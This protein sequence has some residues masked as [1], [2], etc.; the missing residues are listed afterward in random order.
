MNLVELK[1]FIEEHEN[2][3]DHSWQQVAFKTVFENFSIIP[4]KRGLCKNPL[5]KKEASFLKSPLE[6][7]W[8]NIDYKSFEELPKNLNKLGIP[9]HKNKLIV[10]DVDDPELFNQF[11][12]MNNLPTEY[13]TFTVGT[14]DKRYHLYFNAPDDGIAYPNTSDHN[15]GFD[16]RG[17]KCSY[18]VSFASLHPVTGK[19]Y[20]ILKSVP[21]MDA[22]E[23]VLNWLLY[24]NVNGKVNDSSSSVL[25]TVPQPESQMD[26]SSLP[27]TKQH[28]VENG[29][30]LHFR[31]EPSIGVM[32]SM[33][34]NGFTDDQIRKVYETM[35]IGEKAR[36]NGYQWFDAELNRAKA[37]VAGLT[38]KNTKSKQKSSKPVQV[39]EVFKLMEGFEYFVDQYGIYYAKDKTTAGIRYLE[40]HSD[41]YQGSILTRYLNQYGYAVSIQSYKAALSML[42]YNLIGKAKPIQ[43]ICRFGRLGDKLILDL[44]TDTGDCIEIS[45]DGY[46]KITQPEVLLERNENI[47]PIEN[48]QMGC[49]GLSACNTFL[50]VQ[51]ITNQN[52]RHYLLMVLVSYLFPEISSP[53]LYFYG[54]QGSGK[55]FRALTL[56]G[57]FDKSTAGVYLGNNILEL[58]LLL[59]KS[60]ITFVDNF[61]SLNANCQN[62]FCLAYSDGKFVKKKNYEDTKT[63]TIDMKC[64][65]MLASVDIPDLQEDFISRTAFLSVK[66]NTG[67]K[68]E[69]DLWKEI[70]NV[71]PMVRGELCW[72]ASEILKII[73]EYEPVNIKRHADF[74]KLGQAYC[75]II[76]DN[77]DEYKNII[78]NRVVSD[79]I[80]RVGAD[81]VVSEIVSLVK[82]KVFYI[83][84]MQDL[85][86]ELK[87]FIDIAEYKLTPSSLSKKIDKNIKLFTDLGITVIDGPKADNGH[88]YAM[89]T[90]D[91]FNSS[92]SA[93]KIIPKQVLLSN[94][95]II[96]SLYVSSTPTEIDAVIDSILNDK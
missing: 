16:G 81:E 84:T 89:V 10:I 3:A 7:N 41:E 74:D 11:C 62:S 44:G 92:N 51:G 19:P 9:C 32:E 77:P 75:K 20:K 27:L 61:S 4:L 80:N 90:D 86:N 83:F 93:V 69:S 42:K 29:Q 40:I 2:D 76:L 17:N 54:K 68:A 53:I 85:L 8:K 22:P 63:I 79:A 71:Y 65:L 88:L 64:P 13:E 87:K 36:E 57:V 72:L 37:F 52:E 6:N 14:H 18:V 33:L 47:A 70:N 1:T 43:K 26:L 73:D 67:I 66:R 78:S 15:F 39:Q 55:T 60:G 91:Y 25:K 23:W 31:S 48:I 5:D 96:S 50:D 34:M 46:Q 45:K 58:A 38:Q 49:S 56:K 28:F 21:I 82:E 12:C 35:P 59:N 95:K 94:P 30:P 24:K